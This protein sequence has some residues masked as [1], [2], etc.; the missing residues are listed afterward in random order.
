M[1]QLSVEAIKKFNVN[2]LKSELPKRCLA[3][4]GKEEELF[5][6]LTDSIQED[7]S[8][9]QVSISLIKDIFMNMFEEQNKNNTGNNEETRRKCYVINDKISSI[10]QRLDKLTLDIHNNLTIIN[11]VRSKKMI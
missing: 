8:D 6:R 5:K 3:V 2:E 7:N 1:N 10:N 4:Q 9:K 11:K